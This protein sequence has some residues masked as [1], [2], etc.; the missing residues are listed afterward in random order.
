[1]GRGQEFQFRLF[2]SYSKNHDS[3]IY[4]VS[5]T[6]DVP[7]SRYR[8]EKI[9][10]AGIYLHTVKLNVQYVNIV[11]EMHYSSCMNFIERSWSYLISVV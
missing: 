6:A 10:R 1:M 7:A 4:V 3:N 8:Y 9:S 11:T 2:L 5:N